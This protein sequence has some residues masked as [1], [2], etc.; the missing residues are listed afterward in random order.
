VHHY[1]TLKKTNKQGEKTKLIV[2]AKRKITTILQIEKIH[3][4]Q[5][6]NSTWCKCQNRSGGHQIRG[7]TTMP[8]HT[9]IIFH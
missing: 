4:V 6:S 2:Y 5:D 9:F 8:T 1:G 3:D 7:I